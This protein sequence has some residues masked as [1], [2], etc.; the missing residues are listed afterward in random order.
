MAESD[1]RKNTQR[2]DEIWK[3]GWQQKI[4]CRSRRQ[5]SE[6]TDRRTGRKKFQMEGARRKKFQKEGR[7]QKISCPSAADGWQE[8][9]EKKKGWRTGRTDER[10]VCDTGRNDDIGNGPALHNESFGHCSATA[11][12]STPKQVQIKRHI[13]YLIYE[14]PT[15]TPILQVLHRYIK[16]GP[17][18]PEAEARAFVWNF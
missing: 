6:G 11:P 5:M 2:A 17:I 18:K 15:E 1:R 7:R 10:W 4:F 8:K 9:T 3:R 12:Q 14:T 16:M 13:Y